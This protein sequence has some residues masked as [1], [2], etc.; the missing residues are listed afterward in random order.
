MRPALVAVVF[1][2]AACSA[3]DTE[4]LPTDIYCGN[5]NCYQAR[6]GPPP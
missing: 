4:E 1:L 3:Q 2:A 5:M 6:P